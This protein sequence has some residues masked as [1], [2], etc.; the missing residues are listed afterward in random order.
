MPQRCGLSGILCEMVLKWHCLRIPSMYW[1]E[2]GMGQKE[3][4][5]EEVEFAGWEEGW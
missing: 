5:S 1:R 3:R 4:E 2:G